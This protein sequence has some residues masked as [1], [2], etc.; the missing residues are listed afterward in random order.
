MLLNL[1]K[2][3]CF[4][5]L[6]L[7]TACGGGAE[8]EFTNQSNDSM[9]S[10]ATIEERLTI[11][12]GALPQNQSGHENFVIQD[13]SRLAEVNQML[14]PNEPNSQLFPNI[15]FNTQQ[16]VGVMRISSDSCSFPWIHS[17]IVGKDHY[18]VEVLKGTLDK[19]IFCQQAISY[20]VQ[21]ALIERISN[22]EPKFVDLDETFDVSEENNH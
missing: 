15:N 4:C 5:S 21:F 10:N 7:I 19:N 2:K 18:E 11:R 12:F 14:W 3:S 17:V 9:H 20:A 1:L 13:S 22:L 8:I 6:I 16:I